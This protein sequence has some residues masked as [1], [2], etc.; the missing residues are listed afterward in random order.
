MGG[1][2]SGRTVRGGRLLFTF[3]QA[4]FAFPPNDLERVT[5]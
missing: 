4:P 3:A 1:G 5:K 2:G